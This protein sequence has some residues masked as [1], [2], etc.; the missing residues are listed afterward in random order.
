MCDMS[1]KYKQEEYY[2]INAIEERLS[3][4]LGSDSWENIK[5][6][7][8]GQNLIA[9]G[10]NVVHMDAMA[11][12][13]GLNQMFKSTV[14]LQGYLEEIAK[15]KG[16]IPKTYISA[17][18]TIT[19]Y[20]KTSIQSFLPMD[21]SLKVGGKTF[22]N[23]DDVT[24][25]TSTSPTTVVLYEGN[26]VREASSAGRPAGN[27]WSYTQFKAVQ[28]EK[29]GDRVVRK[30]I[31]LPRE[32]FVDSI[33]V[34]SSVSWDV[35]FLRWNRVKTWYGVRQSDRAWKLG[36]DYLG[37]YIIEFGDG[38]Y[39]REYP[40][41]EIV[42][43]RY[44]LSGGSGIQVADFA[45]IKLYKQ[46]INDVSESFVIGGVSDLVDGQSEVNMGDLHL[47]IEESDNARE[48]LITEDDHKNYLESRADV[49]YANIK[50]ERHSNP[51]NIKY[52]NTVRYFVKPNSD[53]G[54]FNNS[55]ILN[56]L[57]KRGL[58]TVEY[59]NIP[60]K[61]TNFNVTV[62]FRALAG[63]I[64]SAVQSQIQSVISQEF[65]WSGLGFNETISE[66]RVYSLIKDV[67]GLDLQSLDVSVEYVKTNELNGSN[68]FVFHTNEVVPLRFYPKRFR[69][70]LDS[71]SLVMSARDNGA[72]A[73]YGDVKN[74]ER[75]YMTTMTESNT[76]GVGGLVLIGSGTSEFFAIDVRK[77]EGGVS[78]VVFPSNVS[79]SC[80]CDRYNEIVTLENV[81]G[82]KIRAYSFPESFLDIEGFNYVQ[83]S[84]VYTFSMPSKEI[85]LSTPAGAVGVYAVTYFD[86]YIYVV[87]Q[88]GSG[89]HRLY[90]YRVMSSSI[91]TEDLN[92]NGVGYLDL[93]EKPVVSIIA[94]DSGLSNGS[95]VL[96]ISTEGVS[97]ESGLDVV[98]DF[99]LS[100][101]CVF[102]LDFFRD[103]VAAQFTLPV[104]WGGLSTSNGYVYSVVSSLDFSN[105]VLVRLGSMG[106]DGSCV[107]KIL[108]D[109]SVAGLVSAV[110]SIYN[111]VA[112]VFAYSKTEYKLYKV[113]F[114]GSQVPPIVRAGQGSGDLTSVAKLA[115][116]RY[117]ILQLVFA[118]TVTG[119]LRYESETDLA[120]VDEEMSVLG[121]LIIYQG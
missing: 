62:V 71:D 22:Y 87:W 84:D 47:E 1:I 46:D 91:D 45:G 89:N 61:R 97:G 73:L 27:S 107:I 51:P 59:E 76:F 56:V 3:K 108:S 117:D 15:S 36:K 25:G 63:F 8:L 88:M 55:D 74:R 65:D 33:I 120:F 114:D 53:G 68:L 48:S 104:S 70:F 96:V 69:L 4:A 106:N 34:E 37:R 99:D 39:G 105:P 41:S 112:D 49:L 121:E 94:V 80:W 79:A 102:E 57:G 10:A 26:V 85:A 52:F 24:I 75:F 43:I 16:V 58:K 7:D 116:I 82:W 21:L 32:V 19:L 31:I 81:S 92:Y 83:L 86:G 28:S 42:G 38:V 54:T 110:Y 23:V 40:T 90:R 5:K 64:P 101:E 113:G 11:F 60:A 72:G 66:E 35:P 111:A 109:D 50:A 67:Q 103:S 95:S 2:D 93:S 18:L 118:S 100:D 29:I 13:T 14:S 6:T 98:V 30:Y 119:T 12:F 20:A 78:K 77:A 44:I 17:N 115:D 9:F